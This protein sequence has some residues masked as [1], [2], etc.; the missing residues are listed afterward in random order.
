MNT[1]PILPDVIV[2]GAGPVGLLTALGM[3]RQGL[4]VTVLET[5]AGIQR[6]PRAIV[7]HWY[8]LEGLQRLGL[9]DDALAAGLTKQ[10]LTYIVLGTGETVSW[11][12]DVLAER[13]PY[14]FNLHLG[15]DR[16][17]DI[18]L[19]HLIRMPDV[20]VHWHTKVTAVSQ[21]ADAVHVETMHDG[22]PRT[23]HGR[24]LVGADGARSAVR[25]ALSPNFDGMTWPERF[26]ATNVRFDFE[27]HGFARSTFV[28]DPRHGAIIV[29]I[30][31]SGLWRFTY[32]ESDTLPQEGI[33]DRFPG[34]FK[35]IAGTSEDVEL[36]QYSPYRMHQRVAD[37]LRVGRILLAGDAAHITNPTGGLGLA[38]GLLDAYALIDALGGVIRKRCP[39]EMLDHYARER[40]RVFVELTSPLASD[41]KRL[42]FHCEDAAQLD[43]RLANARRM[44]ADP[45]FRLERLLMAKRMRSEITVSA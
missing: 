22:A 10:E 19:E 28:V 5:E 27:A 7:Y 39:Q 29:K 37:A 16:L 35:H 18:I 13:E 45:A 44:S 34:M 25:T 15:Q 32:C 17:A 11:S 41:N 26:V 20:E 38:T 33:A 1:T 21:D 9:L 14:P 24:W 2:V 8:V 23:F 36:V 4:K 30:D 42:V 40:R 3:A 31:N 43:Q 12:L 6:S